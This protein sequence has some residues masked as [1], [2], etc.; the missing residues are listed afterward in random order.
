M[1]SV[2][3]LLLSLAQPSTASILLDNF[4]RPD[5]DNLGPNWTAR[6]GNA[7]I[8][9]NRAEALGGQRFPN[10]V[11]Y[12]NYTTNATSV[13][14]F[15]QGTGMA[16]YIALV[17]NYQDLANNYFIKIQ[18]SVTGTAFETYGFYYGNNGTGLFGSLITPITS[19]TITATV[20]GTFAILDVLPTSGARQVYTY[21]FGRETGGNGI[22]LGFYGG[23]QGDDFAD[24]VPEPCTVISIISCVVGLACCRRYRTMRQKKS[25]RA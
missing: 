3:L 14:V 19:G 18:D 11:T 1:K 6:A 5:A 24:A 8:I 2:I 4:D 13:D 21:N 25:R 23:V 12:N 17:L 20:A 16:A 7:E 10:L 15:D 22:G 9:G